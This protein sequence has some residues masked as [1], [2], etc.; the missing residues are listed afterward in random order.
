MFLQTIAHA[1]V[2]V[3]IAEFGAAM[4]VTQFFETLVVLSIA[5]SAAIK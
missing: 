1:F 5:G 3:P 2:V 4:E